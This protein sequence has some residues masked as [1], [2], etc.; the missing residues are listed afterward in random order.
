VD[1]AAELGLDFE[2]VLPAGRKLGMTLTHNT[3]HAVRGKIGCKV[4]HVGEGGAAVEAA[5]QICKN[6]TCSG[7]PSIIP[8]DWIIGVNGTDVSD[9]PKDDVVAVIKAAMATGESVTMR[10]R[11]SEESEAARVAI[12]LQGVK[13]GGGRERPDSANPRDLRG[14]HVHVY[15]MDAHG[16]SVTYAGR[17]VD[18]NPNDNLH[19]IR[20]DDGD[21]EWHDMRQTRYDV[22]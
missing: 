18:Y 6:T 11:R 15:W 21:E 3:T 22:V 14:K 5:G 17:V 10:F 8:S 2:I 7:E 1:G 20:Y 13:G 9:D 16:A 19:F 12:S 4:T